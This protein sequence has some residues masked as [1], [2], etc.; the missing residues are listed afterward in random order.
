MEQNNRI[1]AF[2][3][4]MQAGLTLTINVTGIS[5]LPLLKEG[6]LIV[7][8]KA[9]EYKIGSI[10]VFNYKSGIIVHRLVKQEGSRLFCKGDNALRIEDVLPKDVFGEVIQKNGEPMPDANRET[11]FLSRLENVVFRGKK[12]DAAST[13]SDALF[14][15][16]HLLIMNKKEKT[17]KFKRNEKATFLPVD[18]TSLVALNPETEATLLFDEIGIDVLNCITDPVDLDTIFNEICKKYTGSADQIKKD[19]EELLLKCV[20]HNILEIVGEGE[21]NG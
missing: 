21:S 20:K 16:C 2:S 8:K 5:M 13:R 11:V 6:D 1:A 14:Q 19:V 15:K 12:Y 7:V 3:A 17:M 4:F 18:E 10:L 9:A